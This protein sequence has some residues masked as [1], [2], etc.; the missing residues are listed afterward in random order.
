M[1]RW[2]AATTDPKPK[3]KADESWKQDRLPR[4]PELRPA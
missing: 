1:K 4:A 3:L 2:R